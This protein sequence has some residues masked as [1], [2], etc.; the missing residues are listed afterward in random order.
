MLRNV[1]LTETIKWFRVQLLVQM[2]ILTKNVIE[3]SDNTTS[4]FS[5]AITPFLR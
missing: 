1:R 3:Q 4:V 2:V 5:G